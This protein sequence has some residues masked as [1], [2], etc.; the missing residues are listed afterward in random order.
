MIDLETEKPVSPKDVCRMLPGRTGNGVS[1]STVFRWML[2]GCQGQKLESLIVGGVRYTSREAVERFVAR[3][4]G[5][6]NGHSS[7][8][9]ADQTREVQ[10]VEHELDAQGF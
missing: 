6:E 10:R 2:K 3:L 1:L 5:R 4:N 8:R 9:R 7:R